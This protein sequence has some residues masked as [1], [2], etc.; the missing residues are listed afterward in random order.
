MKY[1]AFSSLISLTAVALLSGSARAA[2]FSGYDT[3]PTNNTRL[4]FDPNSNSQAAF[5]SFSTQLNGIGITTDSFEDTT[6]PTT[7]VVGNAID[8]LV[9]VISGTTATFSLKTKAD[10]LVSAPSGTST[11]VQKKQTGVLANGTYP[12]D[13]NNFISVNTTYNF[14]IA[15]SAPVAAFGYFGT[16]LGDNSNVLTMQFY[17]NGTLIP[18]NPTNAVDAGT[19][20]ANSSKFF[21]GFIA[22]NSTQYFDKVVFSNSASNDAIGIDQITIGTPTQ[23]TTSVPEPSSLLGTMLFGGSV[24]LIKRRARRHQAAIKRK[25]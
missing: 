20:S 13:G 2:T 21:Y 11:Q 18:N 5:N 4:L 23:V 22:D 12:T 1:L 7:T 25:E 16:D 8:G 19:G 6:N 9:R 15:F 3:N 14:S 17:N 10:P 24:I